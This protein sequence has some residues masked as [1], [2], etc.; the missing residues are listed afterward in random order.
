MGGLDHFNALSLLPQMPPMAVTSAGPMPGVQSLHQQSHTH[1]SQQQ[2]NHQRPDSY[3]EMNKYPSM[4]SV[5]HNNSSNNQNSS[6][7]QPQQRQPVL[8][9]G[10]NL[11]TNTVGPPP[12]FAAASAN[13]QPSFVPQSNLFTVGSARPVLTSR[14]LAIPDPELHAVPVHEHAAAAAEQDPAAGVR[15]AAGG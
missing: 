15:P 13:M 3:Q 11:N 8:D 10:S 5:N 12:G 9:N 14:C 2:Q 1:Q 6:L 4:N 7:N